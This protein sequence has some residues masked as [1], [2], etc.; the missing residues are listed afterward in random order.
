[1]NNP[2]ILAPAERARLL[3]LA[4]GASV[5]VASIL[6]VAK[7]AAWM[8]TGSVTILASLVDSV[9]DAL[10]SVINL[11][12]VRFSLQPAD[13]EHRFGHGKAEA[14][15]ALAQ[16]AFITGSA[17]FLVLEAG[18]RLL[19]PQPVT[20]VAAGLI[21]I[22]FAIAA[23]LVLL[24]IQRHVIK[25]TQSTAIK[26]DALH[27]ATDF[28]TNAATLIAL[29]LTA[30]GWHLADPLFALVI[31]GYILYSAYGIAREA[32]DLLMDRELPEAVR[33]R[34]VEI[35]FA[36]REVRGVHDLRSRQSGSSYFI[37]L[38]L[39]LDDDLRLRDA[40]RVADAVEDAIARAFPGAEVIVHQD[41]VGEVDHGKVRCEH[42]PMTTPPPNSERQSPR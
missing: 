10:A 32:V 3:N 18:S 21:V 13:R 2:P 20:A 4:T 14:L 40:H 27:Y 16:A 31:A 19:D 26:A 39:E 41:P 34:I 35:A 22:V 30:F 5:T 42:P 23:T 28:A 17:M 37:Q 36:A 33:Q 11:V 1:M 29:G 12:A 38:H 9:M 25:R 6:I 24:L 8:M 7:L 15:A